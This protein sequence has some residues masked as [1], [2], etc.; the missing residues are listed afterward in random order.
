VLKAAAGA[1]LV[2][3]AV[4][5]EYRGSGV[6]VGARSVLFRLT[7]RAPDRTLEAAEVEDLER[8][9]LA[10]LERELHVRRREAGTEG[11]EEG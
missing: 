8:R 10:A 9:V 3:V 1:L 6:G 2:G 5:D 4:V 7:F 11:P